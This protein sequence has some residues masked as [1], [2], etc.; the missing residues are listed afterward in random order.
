MSTSTEDAAK[1]L[2]DVLRRCLNLVKDLKGS[3]F[4]EISENFEEAHTLFSM[5]FENISC[6]PDIPIVFANIFM[7]IKKFKDRIEVFKSVLSKTCKEYSHYEALFAVM[8]EVL[9][10]PVSFTPQSE[11]YDC[12][13]NRA[14]TTISSKTRL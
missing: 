8:S 7:A 11:I 12:Y 6:Y 3:C 1:E 2:K 5:F 13:S 10:N 14:A 4:P 9:H